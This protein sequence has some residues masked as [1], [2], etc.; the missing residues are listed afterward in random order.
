MPNRQIQQHH[1]QSKARPPNIKIMKHIIR[2]KIS[3]FNKIESL[4]RKIRTNKIHIIKWRNRSITI[5]HRA[6]DNCNIL[7][8]NGYDRDGNGHADCGGE[9]GVWKVDGIFEWVFELAD[10]R[11]LGLVTAGFFD[12]LWIDGWESFEFDILA[13]VV[14]FFIAGI[15]AG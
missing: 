13:D 8:Y 3:R 1:K 2:T 9:N 7:E 4:N 14:E 15:Y 12:G 10:E 11:F 5:I 6:V